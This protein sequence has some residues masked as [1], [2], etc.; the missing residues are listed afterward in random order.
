MYF[1][2]A[3]GVFCR[4]TCS[5]I[6][7]SFP[8]LSISSGRG[9]SGYQRGRLQRFDAWVGCH[10]AVEGGDDFRADFLLAHWERSA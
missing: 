9:A 2:G 6:V 8:R 5:G 7:A 10:G 3:K 4:D 1:L